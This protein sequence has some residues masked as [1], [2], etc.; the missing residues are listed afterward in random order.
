M[1]FLL[2]RSFRLGFLPSQL[3]VLHHSLGIRS[4]DQLVPVVEVNLERSQ[5]HNRPAGST[6][7]RNG[8][9]RSRRTSFNINI[10][11]LRFL[12]QRIQHA[13]PLAQRTLLVD[14]EVEYSS[15]NGGQLQHKQVLRF[16]MLQVQQN[17]LFVSLQRFRQHHK[18]ANGRFR[19]AE[20][21]AKKNSISSAATTKHTNN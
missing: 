20:S 21:P 19:V 10:N 4:H 7:R 15:P 18:L 2:E 1:T 12:G 17:V 11:I 8:N 3:L 16:R 5:R 13:V 6:V 14:L 9:R